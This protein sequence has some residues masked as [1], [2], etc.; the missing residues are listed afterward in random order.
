[1]MYADINS[2]TKPVPLIMRHPVRWI[3][4]IGICAPFL[5]HATMSFLDFDLAIAELEKAG[6]LPPAP[7]AAVEILVN[8]ACSIFILS[9]F[10][11]WFGAL[12]LC[13]ITVVST[14]ISNDF[15]NNI[16]GHEQLASADAFTLQLSLAGGLLLI[17]WYD[18][19]LWR[20]RAID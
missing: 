5:Q 4:L 1:M 10:L 11:R 15:W 12:L 9:G 20:T 19:H 18:L 17:A 13:G 7:I 6:F 2:Q 16:A 3:A 14:F 8:L